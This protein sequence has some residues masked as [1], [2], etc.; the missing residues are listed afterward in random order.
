MPII[1]KGFSLIELMV[2]LFISF[3]LLAI[4]FKAIELVNASGDTQVGF[5]NMEL[6]ALQVMVALKKQIVYAGFMGCYDLNQN[7]AILNHT[8]LTS[9]T[10][11]RSQALNIQKNSITIL[12]VAQLE[13]LSASMDDRT[14]LVVRALGGFKKKSVVV[15]GDCQ[16]IEVDR[17]A[18][19]RKVRGQ[20][21]YRI[22][23][24]K[25][26]SVKYNATATIALLLRFHY[27]LKPVSYDRN[28]TFFLLYIFIY[29]SKKR[30]V[31]VNF[32]I[33]NNFT[34][35]DI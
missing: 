7:K 22:L 6:N 30:K 8:G 13:R 9:D 5:S 15:V 4:M 17:I 14:S 1:T 2:A 27:F 25:P 33:G 32:L 18:S 34:S 35:K 20:N 3:L 31:C 21:L 12:R 11:S 29:N 26:L 28:I 10:V 16:S 19:I 23:L 24:T